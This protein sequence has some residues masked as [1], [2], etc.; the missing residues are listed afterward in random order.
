MGQSRA[1]TVQEAAAR[2]AAAQDVGLLLHQYPDGDT[3]GS[4][5]ALALALNARG[6]RTRVDCCDA[7]PPKYAYITRLLPPSPPF[8]P[9]FVCTVDVADPKLLGALAAQ[10]QAAQLCIDHHA[11]NVRYAEEL[12]LDASCGATAMLVREVIAALNVPLT[13][14]LADCLYTGLATDT[15]CFKY[16]N[17]SPAAHRLA[18]ELIEAGADY[19]RINEAMFD[20]KSRAR[21]E[22]ERLALDGMTFPFAGRCAVM[23]ITNEMIAAAGAGENDMEGLAPIPRQVEGVWVGVTMRERTDGRFKVSLRTG[24]RADASAIAARLGGGGHRRAAGCTVDGPLAAARE[25][26]EAA[27]F[28]ELPEIAK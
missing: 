1:V 24:E 6:I 20:C 16:E 3:I 23:V 15:G 22:L 28:A 8:S 5:Y 26:V 9:R 2:L 21:L 12:L 27:V 19:A 4:G 18:A 13:P 14:E 25:T 7:I 11:T 10:G 17:T